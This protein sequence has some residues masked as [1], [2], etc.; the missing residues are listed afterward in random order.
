MRDQVRLDIRNT[1]QQIQSGRLTPSAGLRI[2]EELRMEG[3][4]DLLFFHPEWEQVALDHRSPAPDSI[5]LFELDDA[6]S[7]EVRT[8]L[9]AVGQLH[10]VKRGSAFRQLDR[11]RFE[12][13]PERPADFRELIATLAQQGVPV[14]HILFHWSNS[15]TD[16]RSMVADAAL[17][18]FHLTQSL[19]EQ[20][21][22]HAVRLLSLSVD[23]GD[24]Q[25]A[26]QGAIGSF[27]L[28]IR[29]ENPLYLYKAVTV[30]DTSLPALAEMALAELTAIDA[31][32]QVRV[33]NGVRSVRRLKEVQGTD[34]SALAWRERGVYLITG[35]AGGL[36]HV[37]ASYLARQAR[38]RLVLAGRSPLGNEQQ[39]RVR[40]L[41]RLGA[42]V[43]YVQADVAER[44]QVEQLVAKAK[45]RFGEL[46]GVIHSAGVI[47]DSFLLKKTAAEWEAVLSPKVYGTFHLDEATRGE[48]LDWF[49]LF[50]SVTVVAGNVGQSDY[51]FANSFMDHF[52]AGRASARRPGKSLSLNW[53]LWQDGGM[54]L[55]AAAEQHLHRTLGLTPMS[56]EQGLLAFES[57]LQSPHAQLAILHGA[58]EQIRNL[59]APRAE[60]VA[61]P[62]WNEG[63]SDLPAADLLEPTKDHLK[64]VLSRLT[65]IPASSIASKEPLEAY[66][67]DSV[68]I[69]S[70]TRELEQ[71]FGSLSKT[72]FFEYENIEALSHYFVDHHQDVLHKLF[73]RADAAIAAV[74]QAA[75]PAG[76]QAIA[77]LPTSLHRERR[78]NV[79][80][81]LQSRSGSSTPEREQ[82]M[83]IAIIGLSG[84]Y[85]EARNLAEFW[86]NLQA[87][88][89]SITEIPSER[90]DHSIYFDPDRNRKG[91]C[92]S[93]WGGF[94]SDV[95]KFDPLFFHISP[96]E[97][98]L[99][100]PQ[101]R[102]F[103]QTAWHAFEDAGY[104]KTALQDT[105]VG[106]FVGVM[107]GHYQ[108]YGAEESLKGNVIALNSSSATIANRV[109]YSLNLHGPSM[110]IDTMCSSSLTAIHL[111][112]DSIRKG[113]SDLALAG[114]VNVSIHPNKYIL[115]SQGKFS[116]TDGR[117]RSFGEGGDG[118]VP[119]EGVGAVL[120]KPLH[121]AIEDGDQIYGVI[122]ATS[123]N[124]GGKT[125][126]YTVPSPQAQ[127]RLIAKALERAQIDPR[128][129]SYLEAHGT[130]T[131]LGDPIEITGLMRAFGERTK[132][133]QF[134][135]IGSVK[136][137]IG[138]LESAAGIAGITK[139]LLQMKHERLV[140]SLHAERLNPHIDF[141]RSPFYVQQEL[142]EWKRPVL[143][144]NG[145]RSIAPRRAGV[146]SF[147]A[148][149]SNAHVILEEFQASERSIDPKA[150]GEEA[151]LILLSARNEERLKAYAEQMLKFLGGDADRP[152][153]PSAKSR[154]AQTRQVEQ[155]LLSIA[156]K[157][158][159]VQVEDLDVSILLT[160]YGM[161]R[162]IWNDLL[163]L[164]GQE[165]Q[166]DAT[167]W[168]LLEHHTL[169]TLADELIRAGVDRQAEELPVLQAVQSR[170]FSLRDI[171]FTLQVG[172]EAMEER[173]ALIVSSVEELVEK[174]GRFLAGEAGIEQLYRGGGAD[175]R[176]QVE[177]LVEG[178]AGEAYMRMLLQEG[179]FE[180]LATL[181][182]AGINLDWSLLYTTATDRPKRISL[183]I[184]PFAKERYWVPN[185]SASAS[186]AGAGRPLLT[187]RLHP[188]VERN[189][190][191]LQMQKFSTRLTGAE[192]YLQDHRIDGAQILPAAAY[193]EMARAAGELAAERPVRQI[194]QAV[195]AHPIDTSTE[196]RE[197]HICLYQ[198]G[199]Q[200]GYEVYSE[201]E[202]GEVTLHAQGALKLEAGDS[203]A[204]ERLQLS[205]IRESLSGSKSAAQCYQEFGQMG[206]A[207]GP[208]F[209]SIRE[210]SGDGKSALAEICL[211]DSAA[212]EADR[213]LLHPSLLDGA[214]QTVIGLLDPRESVVPYSIGELIVYR[215]LPERCFAYA[216]RTSAL[217]DRVQKF[218]IVLAD[219]QGN[220]LVRIND[221]TQRVMK[222]EGPR[223]QEII[224]L[225]YKL[226]SGD[227][228]IDD[229]Q[230]LVGNA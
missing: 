185:S 223:R 58:G 215:S 55:D 159:Q 85:P 82:Q 99:M 207:Y 68:L 66:G 11:N 27:A 142:A 162:L 228:E 133:L 39:E 96:K 83:E 98:A 87:G 12:V 33:E 94:I 217:E 118:Y 214:L 86:A 194:E 151:Q 4:R 91:K 186:A 167:A 143:E 220:Q 109:S 209:R 18:L 56:Q 177:L 35:G 165:F 13:N 175:L 7:T 176:H 180:H 164:V 229:L 124:H 28:T 172:R 157:L 218:T 34:R 61:T 81:P 225:F 221:F 206:Y 70:L 149:G 1:L 200:I 24:L 112:C 120:L 97:A 216:V 105:A 50:S 111:A 161:D 170:D 9:P 95:D 65:K 117:C 140:P 144:A 59:F 190:S 227:I 38:A 10:V 16:I 19:M 211:P 187:A 113:E 116:S 205:A 196:E 155:S 146:S 178:R 145:V 103:L 88:K 224:D 226:Q 147:G 131:A 52:A 210:W 77:E 110:A 63:N 45:Q 15:G 46:H 127:G 137:N 213:Y 101:E 195:W 79:R 138:H 40:D 171:A 198:D 169:A 201:H 22:T 121:R 72:L 80:R 150:S 158:L 41:E 6:L 122:K 139:V 71:Q 152:L 197:V 47:R 92:Y 135:A 126:G 160:E 30:R 104:T 123:L 29:Q 44:E 102:M 119:G 181:Y 53:P 182:V 74:P 17:S 21:R 108:L 174:L 25:D 69:M 20:K 75:S 78:K 183:P 189:T 31:D 67:I 73:N 199:E 100:D 5:L 203:K 188:L 62:E 219:E 2:L 136:S 8:R 191:T 193:L 89:D 76:Q 14:T 54:R 107:Y 204:P 32:V 156:S 132:D 60:P 57:A 208:S 148:G 212:Q 48:P 129:I 134:C 192:F 125:N 37:F 128:S 230:R 93:K 184:Y 49:V 51:A 163:D 114:G 154:V 36:G 202:G 64:S 115:L 84:Q 3:E 173:L 153:L 168:T 130:G 23:A 106:V 179:R 26:I 141:E 222:Q 42:E 166:V 43:L 90:W